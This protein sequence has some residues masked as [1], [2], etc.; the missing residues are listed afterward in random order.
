MTKLSGSAHAASSSNKGSGDTDS[1]SLRCTYTRSMDADEVSSLALL[2]TSTWAFIGGLSQR[3]CISYKF[4]NHHVPLVP[5]TYY[6]KIL[7]H[8][9]IV[10]PRS[11]DYETMLR[12]TKQ[13]ICLFVNIE[14]KTFG[15][16]VMWHILVWF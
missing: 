12:K 9:T 6:L 14:I 10:L 7:L 1:Q 13:N 5:D 11:N 15:W 2:D 16:H 8:R 4:Q 3:L